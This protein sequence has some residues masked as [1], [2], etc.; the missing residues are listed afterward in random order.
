MSSSNSKL[1]SLTLLFLV[2]VSFFGLILAVV[3]ALY[4]AVP[5]EDM[6]WRKPLVGS[7]YTAICILGILAVFF[8]HQCSKFFDVGQRKKRKNRLLGFKR[9][10]SIL[11]MSSPT[12][13]G[14]HPTCGHF[15]AHIFCLADKT[16]C[17][18][19]SGLF[20]GALIALTGVATYFFGNLQT[21]Q[22]AFLMVLIGVVGVVLGLL[23][24]P[25]PT[26]QNSF[27]RV[28]SSTFFVAGTFLILIGVDGLTHNFLID[29]FFVVF[30]VFWLFTRIS[31]SKWDHERICSECT[32]D[33]CSFKNGTQ[34]REGQGD[35]RR[36]S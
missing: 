3:F 2:S 26:L 8:P 1:E 15:S 4:P 19:C 31:L 22:N 20:L 14:H 6:V 34:K 13:L 28:F 17:A 35:Y 30:S 29:L 24:S 11:D 36:L 18:T 27:I 23:Q 7:S 12:L 33:S 21:E 32:I 9:D 16:L 25:L 10:S 5:Q